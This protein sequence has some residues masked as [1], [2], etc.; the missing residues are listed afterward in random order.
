MRVLHLPFPTAE[1]IQNR[2]IADRRLTAAVTGLFLGGS[3]IILGILLAVGGPI[4]AL[5]ALV[6]VQFAPELLEV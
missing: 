5:G 6:G 2:L 3:A 4:I 1:Q